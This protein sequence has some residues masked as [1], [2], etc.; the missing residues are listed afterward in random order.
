MS[1]AWAPERIEGG[2][3]VTEP[4]FELDAFLPAK[5]VHDDIQGWIDGGWQERSLILCGD[6][7][8]GKTEFG[9]ALM[10][11]VAPSGTF[12]FINKLDRVR[13]I[14]FCPGQGLV[15]DEACFWCKDVDD[16]KGLLYPKKGAD[17]ACRNKDGFI[18]RGVPRIFSTNWSWDE[19]WPP[20]A[21][22]RKH[23]GAIDRRVVWVD[24]T[25]D[26]RQPERIWCA[27]FWLLHVR[28]SME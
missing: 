20:A 4:E 1:L 27:G 2:T 17:V 25:H 11:K 6:P 7:G 26:I 21:S 12:H 24:V 16:L 23:A 5:S 3:L 15:V 18:P 28:P 10:H 22:K 19:F 9:C 13:D 14:V 8:V